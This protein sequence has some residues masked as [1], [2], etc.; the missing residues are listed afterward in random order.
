MARTRRRAAAN[1]P[2]EEPTNEETSAE[3]SPPNSQSAADAGPKRNEEDRCPACKDG[4]QE[5]WNDED[6][7]SWVRCDACRVWFHWRCVG[8]G[9]L[10]AIGKWCAGSILLYTIASE[11]RAG[12]T[13]PF[14]FGETITPDLV[15]YDGNHTY[16]NAPKG[17]AI[18]KI[19]ARAKV[20][21]TAKV[22]IISPFIFRKFMIFSSNIKRKTTAASAEQGR[23]AASA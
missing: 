1:G 10:E 23:L 19:N 3:T 12:T 9:D 22:M 7:E 20:I 15:N 18:L 6:K 21:F 4:T 11:C 16:A 2:H 13:T 5:G 17:T 14:H 8:D